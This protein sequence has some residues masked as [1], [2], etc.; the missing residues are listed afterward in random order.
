MRGVRGVIVGESGIGGSFGRLNPAVED[1]D[2]PVLPTVP[3][4]PGVVQPPKGPLVNA[5]PSRPD[6]GDAGTAAT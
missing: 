2:A 5:L 4:A 6:D 1:T 3:A